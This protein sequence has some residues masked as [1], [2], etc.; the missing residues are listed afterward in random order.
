[1]SDLMLVVDNRF[2]RLNKLI[3]DHIGSEAIEGNSHNHR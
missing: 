3:F 1:M 2:V